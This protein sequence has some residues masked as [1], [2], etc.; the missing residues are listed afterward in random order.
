MLIESLYCTCVEGEV[1]KDHY[2]KGTKEHPKC[3]APP[4]PLP[5]L[6]GI[7]DLNDTDDVHSGNRMSATRMLTCAR[8][9]ALEDNIPTRRVN[10]KHMNSPTWGTAI[11]EFMQKHTPPG[12]YQEV[13]LP[14]KGSPPV[15]LFEGTEAEVAV[16]GRLDILTPDVVLLQDYKCTSESSQKFRWNRRA[17]D[18]EWRAQASIYK[19]VGAKSTEGAIDIK[20]AAVWSGSMTSGRCP[21]PPWFEI[22]LAWMGEEEILVM[23]PHGGEFSV[24]DNIV[25]FKTFLLAKAKL[26]EEWR[27]RKMDSSG[28]AIVPTEHPGYQKALKAIIAKMPLGGR[29][30]WRGE[31][32]KTY[33]TPARSCNELEGLVVL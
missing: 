14:P 16:R 13:E 31:M 9:I 19:I 29:G 1:P 11:H 3:I 8:K 25:Q 24:A 17:A 5:W 7:L 18:P 32:C 6:L 23:K 27:L 28:H 12:Y 21:A 33:C 26:D 20:R 2:L 4:M 10:L 22:P 15:L 30:M